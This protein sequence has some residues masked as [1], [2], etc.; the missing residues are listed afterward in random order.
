[1]KEDDPPPAEGLFRAHGGVRLHNN[2]DYC[3]A[4]RRGPLCTPRRRRHR[5]TAAHV[6]AFPIARK[7]RVRVRACIIVH[8]VYERCTQRLRT[9]TGCVRR[10]RASTAAT[11]RNAFARG[12]AGVGA[13]VPFG[14]HPRTAT[15]TVQP[16]WPCGDAF[17]HWN[18][19]LMLTQ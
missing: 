16:P 2:N 9:Y 5:A 15:P 7:H 4:L 11:V 8:V 19:T 3:F 14:H 17:G 6:P 12:S 18:V 10:R 13:T 1:M